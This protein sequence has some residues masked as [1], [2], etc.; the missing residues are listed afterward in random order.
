MVTN[1]LSDTGE[2]R[3]LG[4]VFTSSI[5]SKETEELMKLNS[6]LWMILIILITIFVNLLI[7]LK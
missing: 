3:Q 2:R 7:Y 6:K 4:A 5:I 1:K